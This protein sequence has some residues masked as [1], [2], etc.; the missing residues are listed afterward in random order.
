L[1][2]WK[3]VC[4][5]WTTD[6]YCLI[7]RFLSPDAVRH[8]RQMAD[9]A[10]DRW[11]DLT[12][13]AGREARA[14][15]MATLT[16]PAYWHGHEQ[17]LTDLLELIAH[18]QILGMLTSWYGSPPL[19]HNTQ[20]FAEQRAEAWDGEW[21]RDSQFLA[22]DAELERSRIAAGHGVHVRFA[23]VEDACFEIVPGSHARWDTPEEW[24]TRRH[25]DPAVRSGAMAGAQ[26]IVMQPGDMLVF[27]AWSVHRGRYAPEPPRRTL[28]VIYQATGIADYCPPPP[29][30]LTDAAVLAAL[31]PRARAFFQHF[32]DAYGPYWAQGAAAG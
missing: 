20:Y 6:G 7:P 17:D 19:F 26:T 16:D 15:N 1:G 13:G 5:R 24:T 29:T 18:P 2:E 11:W 21:H 27:H 23:F 30:C 25:A 14:S 10:Y 4:D 22:A 12:F 3:T 32:A 9:R 28:D 31:N 8:Y